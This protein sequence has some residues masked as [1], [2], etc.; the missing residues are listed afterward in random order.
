MLINGLSQNQQQLPSLGTQSNTQLLSKPA[1][2]GSVAITRA[3]PTTSSD[4]ATTTGSTSSLFQGIGGAIDLISNVGNF[5][6]QQGALS[7][8]A[9]GAMIGTYISPGFG[10]IVGAAI[11]GI[12]GGIMGFIKKSGKPAEQ[13]ERDKVREILQ[14][15]GFIDKD[16]QIGLADGSKYNIGIDGKPKAEYGG[17]RPHEVDFNR[18]MA[19]YAVAWMNPIAEMICGSNQ[20]LK[21]AFCGYFANAIMSNAKTIEDV[22]KNAQAIIGQFGMNAQTLLDKLGQAAQ[23]GQLDQQTAAI[24]MNGV[25]EWTSVLSGDAKLA[26]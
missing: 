23:A 12:A 25:K 19:K 11:G 17:L 15:Q 20:N 13:K 7:G 10:T 21:V 18:P 1:T 6:P 8:A 5:T 14:Q 22:A 24:Y 16:F 9:T 26:A 4:A 2:S 3:V